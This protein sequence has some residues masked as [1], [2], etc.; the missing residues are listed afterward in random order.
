[1]PVNNGT[2]NNIY[3]LSE[4]AVI[5]RIPGYNDAID[6]DKKFAQELLKGVTFVDL[7][8]VSYKFADILTQDGKFKDMGDIFE[9]LTDIVKKPALFE[10][11]TK[12]MQNIFE[13]VLQRMKDSKTM[14]LADDFTGVKRLRI[15]AAND[16]TFNEVYNNDFS[17]DNFLVETGKGVT[18]SFMNKSLTKPGSDGKPQLSATGGIGAMVKGAIWAS[19]GLKGMNYS[20]FI[21]LAGTGMDAAGKQAGWKDILLGALFGMSI[22]APKQWG[23]SGYSSTLSLFIK[24]VAPVGTPECV[25]RNILEPLLYLIAAT[26]P[27][28]YGGTMFG[29]P[30]LW[31]V[32]AH[33]ITRFRLGAIATLSVIR[34]SFETTFNHALQ[35]TVVD[36]RLTIVPLLTDFAV[37]TNSN[38]VKHNIYDEKNDKYL[39][40]QHPGDTRV[41]TMNDGN[42]NMFTIQL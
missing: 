18:S 24:L 3:D 23:G 21:S 17:Q 2:A 12:K 10:Q 38:N 27:V 14:D 29:F 35:P 8:P 19:K 13:G 32:H 11:D 26:S 28:T 7:S 41:G 9:N 22:A 40:V 5:G 36:V 20:D 39:S 25:R 42:A 30:L 37:Q 15:I 16:S 4:T 33:G 34:G 31:E 6:P 1:M